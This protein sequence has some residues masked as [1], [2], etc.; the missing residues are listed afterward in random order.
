MFTELKYNI[1]CLEHVNNFYNQFINTLK[2]WFS[3]EKQTAKE[4]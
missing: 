3:E 4:K 2:N 1:A